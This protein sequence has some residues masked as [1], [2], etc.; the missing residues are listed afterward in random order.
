MK[1]FIDFLFVAYF[2]VLIDRERQ[3]KSIINAKNRKEA[4]N[5]FLKKIKKDLKGFKIKNVKVF[6]LKKLKYR[7]KLITDKQWDKLQALSYPNKRHKLRKIPKNQW[8]KPLNYPSRNLDGTFKN[9][10]IP[11][12]KG[13]KLKIFRKDDFGKFIKCRDN[14]GKFK[15]GIKVAVVGHNLKKQDEKVKF[16]KSNRKQ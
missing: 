10:F 5:I 14:F 7:G 1:P 13:L 8:F 9:G 3:Y 2:S 16:K 15:K 4:K 6:P 11:W 12:N